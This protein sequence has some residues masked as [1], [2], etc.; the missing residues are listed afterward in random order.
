MVR[1]LIK[2]IVININNYRAKISKKQTES[3]FWIFTQ[4]DE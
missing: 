4:K 1:F 2:V 3:A